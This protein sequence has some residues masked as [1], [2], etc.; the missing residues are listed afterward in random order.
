MLLHTRRRALGLL[1]AAGAALRLPA[2]SPALAQAK[3]ECLESKSFGPWRAQASDRQAGARIN[4][5]NFDKPCDLQVQIQVSDSYESKLVIYG[6][7]DDA[8]LPKKFLVDPDN[9]LIVRGA[10]G[11]PAVDEPLCGNCTDIFDDKVSIV[12]P[13]ATSPLLREEKSIEI[14]IKLAEK[15]ECSF[16][17]DGDRLRA[18]LGW[19]SERKE[20]L[21]KR[22]EDKECTSPEGC[23]ITTAC[24]GTLGLGEDCFELTAL[25]C[26][27]DMVLAKQRDGAV[28]IA[29]YY[30]LAPLILSRMQG[31]SRVG[32]LRVIYA[33]YI[34]PAALAAR[35]GMNGFAYRLYAR[36]V[37]RLAAEFAP[38]RAGAQE[39]LLPP[40]HH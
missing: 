33:R 2:L 35:L 18:A 34:L 8:P 16:K 28:K 30:E 40:R 22:A 27:R 21:A 37:S 4:E 31:V 36:M 9:R 20:A 15:D 39:L 13:L 6:D 24:C 32:R 1:L 12:M 14:S 10:N 38:E 29:I 7:P 26:Y 5:V 23:F 25:R 17:L 11:E 3:K 19:A